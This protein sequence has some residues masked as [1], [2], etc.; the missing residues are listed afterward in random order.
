[1]VSVCG[2]WWARPGLGQWVER[3]PGLSQCEE[4]GAMAALDGGR[5]PARRQAL[6]CKLAGRLQHSETRCVLAYFTSGYTSCA[7]GFFSYEEALIHQRSETF[8]DVGAV[9]GNRLRCLQRAATGEDRQPAEERRL[10]LAQQVVAPGDR[11][12]Q[13]LLPGRQIARSANQQSQTL[14]QPR[15]QPFGREQLDARC[16]Q[17][18][19]QRQPIQPA[20]DLGY[21]RRALV[22]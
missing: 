5:L 13:C 12:P 10:F 6:A 16:R 9:A 14:L 19:R 2:C 1:E 7:F 18:D 17:L 15:Q 4:I 20:A 21:H 11:V 3:L 22:R 8:E